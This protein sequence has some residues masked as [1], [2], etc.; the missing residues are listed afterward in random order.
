MSADPWHVDRLDLAGYLERLG[1]AVRAFFVGNLK[2]LCEIATL[3]R[4]VPISVSVTMYEPLP[5]HVLP[6]MG[7]SEAAAMDE[8]LG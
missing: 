2:P 5:F 8:A 3:T 4:L 1:V 7:E 6:G